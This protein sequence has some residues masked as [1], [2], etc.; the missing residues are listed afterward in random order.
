M[1]TK[2]SEDTKESMD[3]KKTKYCDREY[4]SV[5][6][7][8]DAFDE[9]RLP[10]PLAP[11][12]TSKRCLYFLIRVFTLMLCTVISIAVLP[13]MIIGRCCYGACPLV[14]RPRQ[15]F[16]ILAGYW[17]RKSKLSAVDAAMLTLQLLRKFV[18]GPTYAVAFYLDKVLYT[19]ASYPTPL[20][21][22][23]NARS[24]STEFGLVISEFDEELY[25]IP[26][27]FVV[28]PFRWVWEILGATVGR[29]IS[30]E[31]FSDAI[32]AD[33]P[34]VFTQRHQPRGLVWCRAVADTATRGRVSGLYG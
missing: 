15:I 24:G 17:H 21:L 27:A 2:G 5:K 28:M 6:Q 31:Q 3:K 1:H 16:K 9:A 14:A 18:Q 11:P 7:S 33:M 25:P 4:V 22:L 29:F 32:A 8:A 26:Y 30:L 23:S 13:L 19:P 12:P 34:E 10:A 20:F